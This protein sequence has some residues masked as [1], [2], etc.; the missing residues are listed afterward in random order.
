MLSIA[1]DT[2]PCSFNHFTHCPICS[3]V[4]AYARISRCP[5][6]FSGPHTHISRLPMSIPATWLRITPNFY[7]CTISLFGC[8]D[9]SFFAITFLRTY[10]ARLAKM[11]ILI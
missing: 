5:S 6:P 11:R 3:V 4:V 1:T 7:A 9:L 2:T 10:A 8:L